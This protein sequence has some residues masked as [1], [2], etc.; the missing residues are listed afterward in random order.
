M[1]SDFDTKLVLDSRLDVSDKI[2]YGV[3]Q[4]GQNVSYQTYNAVTKSTTNIVFTVQVPSETVMINRYVMWEGQVKM[5]LQLSAPTQSAALPFQYGISE[6]FAA[7][8]LHQLVTTMNCIINNTTVSVQ[9]QDILPLII[10]S[11]EKQKLQMLN[12]ETPT[13][14]DYWMN[15]EDSIAS[16]GNPL[17]NTNNMNDQFLAPRGSFKLDSVIDSN[18]NVFN[19]FDTTTPNITYLDITATFREP[20]LCSP[21]LFAPSGHNQ[22]CMYGVQNM[23][24]NFSIDP[25]CSRAYRCSRYFSNGSNSPAVRA[26]TYT[27][28]LQSWQKCNLVIQYVTPK[29]GCGF[30][31]SARN[32]LPYYELPRYFTNIETPFTVA[33]PNQTVILNTLQLN[34]IPDKCFIYLRPVNRTV[35]DPDTFLVINSVKVTF[36]NNSG[37]LSTAS[38]RDLWRMTKRNGLD[39]SWEEFSGVGVNNTAINAGRVNAVKVPLSGSILALSFGE[40]IQINDPYYASGSIGNFNLQIELNVTYQ[41]TSS[42]SAL[43]NGTQANPNGPA[44]APFVA[45]PVDNV[46]YQAVLVIMNSGCCVIE[47]G[48]TSIFTALL[49]KEKVLET[50]KQYNAHDYATSDKGVSVHRMIGG[51]DLWGSIKGLANDVAGAVKSV[52]PVAKNVL[53]AIPDPRAQAASKVLSSLGAG[54]SGGKKSA[55]KIDSYLM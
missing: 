45:S 8:P 53:G 48:V 38:Q 22:Q 6:A 44:R 27:P 40:D 24:F 30:D 31:L 29:A 28:S 9:M 52:A 47:K 50:N 12:G 33:A 51:F 41:Q 3:H 23:S 26:V 36:N 21:F 32:V 34:Q 16:I 1:S 5:R 43:T 13:M 39:I 35:Y 4:S 54:A 14:S 19:P 20:L 25:T 10:K 55:K 17:A 42:Y 37:I 46:R 18:G 7:F 2:V 11:M 15:Y 49:S